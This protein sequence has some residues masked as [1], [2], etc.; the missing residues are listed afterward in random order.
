MR[1]FWRVYWG[2]A[3]VLGLL[4]CAFDWSGFNKWNPDIFSPKPLSEVWWHF[5]V[6]LGVVL[7]GFELARRNDARKN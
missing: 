1:V 5:P 2:I 4:V 3:V 6:E 7:G